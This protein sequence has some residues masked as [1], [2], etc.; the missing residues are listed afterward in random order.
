M[1]VLFKWIRFELSVSVH[2]E[3][4]LLY[5]NHLEFDVLLSSFSSKVWCLVILH[6]TKIDQIDYMCCGGKGTVKYG[7][8]RFT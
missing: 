7:L 8:F 4:N 3:V 5:K 6:A 1:K 2:K